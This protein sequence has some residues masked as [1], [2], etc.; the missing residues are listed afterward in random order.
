M[1]PV[2]A[3]WLCSAAMLMELPKAALPAHRPHALALIHSEP[4]L[5]IA[6]AVLGFGVHLGTFLVIKTTNSVTL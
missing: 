3:L 1:A 4:Q 5:F 2:S 6:S